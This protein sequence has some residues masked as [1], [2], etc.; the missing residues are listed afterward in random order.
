M[1]ANLIF[2]SISQHTTRNL[3]FRCVTISSNNEFTSNCS[4]KPSD[5]N[6]DVIP[7]LCCIK[8]IIGFLINTVVFMLPC[9][10]K[11]HRK[12]SRIYIFNLAV[13]DL[14]LLSILPLWEIYYSYKYAWP[15]GLVIC[16]FLF[17]SDP[18]RVCKHFFLLPPWVLYQSVIYSFL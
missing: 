7:I 4:W 12:V 17:F 3:H 9:C 16:S 13:A 15:F 6:L 14:L 2:A 8:F 10:Q 5:K 11:G 1:N 18:E